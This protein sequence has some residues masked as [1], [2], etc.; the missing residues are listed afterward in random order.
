[1][2]GLDQ[3]YQ[4]RGGPFRASDGEIAR[5]PDATNQGV[6][7]VRGPSKVP[8]YLWGEAKVGAWTLRACKQ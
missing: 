8:K 5:R 1:V 3:L 6:G 4:E 2:K 7:N